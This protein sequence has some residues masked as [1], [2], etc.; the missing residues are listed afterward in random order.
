MKNS[1]SHSIEETGIVRLK[2]GNVTPV[3]KKRNYL[4]KLNYK[5]VSL[6]RLLSN[7]YEQ[8]VYNQLLQHSEHF[9]DAILC[10]FRKAHSIQLELFKILQSLQK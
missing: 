1:I 10:G 4:E 8:I 5:P 2:L 3:F 7:V 9:L 6:L